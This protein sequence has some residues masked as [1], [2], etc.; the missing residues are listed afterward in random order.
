[1]RIVLAAL[2]LLLLAAVAGYFG[3]PFL[4]E[5][6]T[7][8][9]RAEVDRLKQ[10]M[11]R[12]ETFVL[13]EEEARKAAVLPPEADAQKIIAAV[14]A[15]AARTASLESALTARIAAVEASQ[16]KQ[17][18]ARDAALKQQAEAIE[19]LKK[20]TAA[21]LQRT[22][23]DA[24]LAAVRGHIAKAR[25][26]LLSKNISTARNEMELIDAALQRMM[27]DASADRK[28][29]I[30]E[31]QATLRKA[32]AEADA[33]LPAALS[34]IDLLW[35]ETGKLLLSAPRSER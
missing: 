29:S 26:D 18:D 25:T 22:A 30:E 27:T 33:N 32:R 20:E 8:G 16:K 14:N 31:L 7:S 2:G 23:F 13:S 5:S 28:K 6:A 35:H 21:A 24:R 1:M 4:L 10:R 17:S 11:E 12:V 9:I 15:L 3:I 19:N 34:R